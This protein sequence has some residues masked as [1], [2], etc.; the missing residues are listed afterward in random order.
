MKKKKLHHSTKSKY[1]FITFIHKFHETQNRI[2]L[3]NKHIY[4]IYKLNQ[5]FLPKS[6]SSI[7]LEFSYMKV[8]II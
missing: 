5:S 7:K 4:S 8:Y 3:Q 2:C 1:F 6:Y